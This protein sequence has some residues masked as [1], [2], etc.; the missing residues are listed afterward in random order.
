MSIRCHFN[1]GRRQLLLFSMHTRTD[2]HTWTHPHIIIAI[3]IICPYT[4]ITRKQQRNIKFCPYQLLVACARR[5]GLLKNKSLT[6]TLQP[7]RRCCCFA[8]PCETTWPPCSVRWWVS[9][10]LRAREVTCDQTVVGV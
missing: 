5:T 9:K 2:T 1:G 8:R 4:N 7:E 6:A 3:T 10:C